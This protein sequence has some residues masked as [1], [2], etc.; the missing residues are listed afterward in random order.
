MRTVFRN[1][2]EVCLKW[3]ENTQEEGRAGNV[4]FRW[5]TIYS[6][7]HYSMA[8]ICEDRKV[9]LQKN[10]YYSH[11][12]SRH[13]LAAGWAA[14]KQGYKVFNVADI[15]GNHEI[16]VAVYLDRMKETVMAFSN[17]TFG[18]WILE[19]NEKIY[20]ELLRYCGEFGL[21]KPITLGLYLDRSY[22]FIAQRFLEVPG[23]AVLFLP[24]WLAEKGMDNVKS[25]D[26]LKTRNAEIRREIIRRIGIERICYDLKAKIIDRQGDYELVLLDLRDGQHRPFLK[27][28]N[29]SVP[30]IWHLEGIHPAIKTVQDALNYRR[31]GDDMFIGVLLLSWTEQRELALHPESAK[32]KPEYE[33]SPL[34]PNENN[35]TPEKL[36]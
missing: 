6:Y 19:K 8:K 14:S 23:G 1:I 20:N 15:G 11:T 17:T 27:M 24:R 21:T 2:G 7:G 10:E 4:S 34:F 16:N 25:K 3:A 30:E 33:T 31:Y 26:I 28:H 35:W 32:I 29:P 18:R 12:T 13:Q 5:D 36:T 22:P 9:V